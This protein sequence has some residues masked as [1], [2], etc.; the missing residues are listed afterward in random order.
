MKRHY[1]Y[2]VAGLQDLNLDIHKLVFRQLAFR[3]E[4]KHELHPADYKLVELLFLPFDNANLLKLL[5][6]SDKAF[7]EKGNY[8]VEDLEENIKEPVNLPSY[9]IKFIN[10]FKN[11]DP[12]YP[13]MSPENELSTLFYDEMLETVSNDFLRAWFGFD[14]HVKNITLALNSRKYKVPY[15]NQ[16]IGT[17]EISEAV[18]K[19][20]A[21]D[22]GLS[23]DLDV[24]DELIAIS[25]REDIKEREQ[26]LDLLKWKYLDDA[27]FFHYFTIERIL[28]FV[29]KLGMIERWL[30]I[31]KDHSNTMFKKLL[32]ELQ[33]SYKLPET[34]TEK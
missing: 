14:L 31:D 19:S 1:Y 23:R 28:A 16:I 33:A 3:D 20:H 7:N 22:F 18:R 15:E 8:T 26:A 34:F 10:A 30:D 2:L 17:N 4:L 21:R 25:R 27:V 24:M 5:T 12:F 11:Q 6:K 29:I 9:M 13:D 32:K